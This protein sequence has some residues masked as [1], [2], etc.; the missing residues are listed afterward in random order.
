VKLSGHL[1]GKI[2]HDPHT[3]GI[4][5]LKEGV[6]RGEALG[7][8]LAGQCNTRYQRSGRSGLRTSRQ[9]HDHPPLGLRSD[10]LEEKPQEAG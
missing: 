1:N 5:D 10:C 8:R 6:S 4:H 9:Y 3:G 7:C 2:R